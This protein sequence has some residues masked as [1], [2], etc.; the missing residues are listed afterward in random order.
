[1]EDKDYVLVEGNMTIADLLWTELDGLKVPCDRSTFVTCEDVAGVNFAIVL[2][3]AQ[4]NVAQY[5]D[6]PLTFVV[7]APMKVVWDLIG[8]GRSGYT[9]H[10]KI[11]KLVVNGRVFEDAGVRF[12]DVIAAALR[13]AMLIDFV[14]AYRAKKM[15]ISDV[16]LDKVGNSI[17]MVVKWDRE[18]YTLIL[19][20]QL[21]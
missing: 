11:P 6:K 2:C 17:T 21:R 5:I 18:S 15:F 14:N 3:G 1:M 12:I 8:D 7:D 13:P 4:Y 20:Y 10:T 9:L 16:E 19:S